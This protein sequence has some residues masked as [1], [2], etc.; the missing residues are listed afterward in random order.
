MRFSNNRHP[1]VNTLLIG[2]AVGM[3]TG[4]ELGVVHQI[5]MNTP[6]HSVVGEVINCAEL[7]FEFIVTC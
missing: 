6:T 7:E 3:K 1:L 2:G 4:W 5:V